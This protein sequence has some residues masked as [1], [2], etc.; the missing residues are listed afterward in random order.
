M[1]SDSNRKNWMIQLIDF[2]NEE[3][4]TEMQNMGD[5]EGNLYPDT[6]IHFATVAMYL[7]WKKNK[8]APDDPPIVTNNLKVKNMILCP[9]FLI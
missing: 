6:N 9:S 2:T 8:R 7:G 4:D 5:Q 1:L 3:I